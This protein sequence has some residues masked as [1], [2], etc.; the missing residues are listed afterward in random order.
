MMP[1]ENLTRLHAHSPSLPPRCEYYARLE[2]NTAADLQSSILAPVDMITMIKA[3]Q[4]FPASASL[5]SYQEFHAEIFV[6]EATNLSI[7]AVD[8]NSNISRPNAEYLHI[9][10]GEIFE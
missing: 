7:L 3:P 9:S 6:L 8:A 4:C 10:T 5:I 2:S 1:Y